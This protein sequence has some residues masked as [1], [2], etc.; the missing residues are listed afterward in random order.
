MKRMPDP[1][2]VP[3]QVIVVAFPKAY[4]QAAWP[5]DTAPPKSGS[6]FFLVQAD[7]QDIVL[8]QPAV[9]W[10]TLSPAVTLAAGLS[11][12]DYHT[13]DNTMGRRS[14][15]IPVVVKG[16]RYAMTFLQQ[17]GELVQTELVRTLNSPLN[18]D[19]LIAIGF[20]AELIQK[21]PLPLKLI[22]L[23]LAILAIV[24]LGF[25]VSALRHAFIGVPEPKP[26]STDT[27][28]VPI[29]IVPGVPLPFALP[30][31]VIA[32]EDQTIALQTIQEIY[33]LIKQ[34]G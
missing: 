22:V 8:P 21:I 33:W 6:D 17:P 11:Q 31:A 29:V 20:V 16:K 34:V 18:I 4:D 23:A 27:N 2:P 26:L 25:V 7:S 28:G 10:L 1:R 30:L 15:E 5:G 12:V 14:T 9:D 32:A 3:G 19:C 24:G 13:T